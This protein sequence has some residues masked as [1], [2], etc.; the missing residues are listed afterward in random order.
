MFISQL[1]FLDVEETVGG[2]TPDE[3][4]KPLTAIRVCVS[5]FVSDKQDG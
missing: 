1:S 5:T 4:A 3:M 2:L